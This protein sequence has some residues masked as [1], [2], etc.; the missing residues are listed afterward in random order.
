MLLDRNRSLT[1]LIDFQIRLMPAIDNRIG[2]LNRGIQL[3]KLA[4][5]MDV[6]VLATEHCPDKIGG[7]E[8]DIQAVS[9]YS[10][11]KTTFDACRTQSLFAAWQQG[12]EQVVVAGVE[13][14][15]CVFQ[16]AISLAD[17]GYKVTVA[18]D[19]IGS[20]KPLDR[21][22]AIAAMARHGIRIATVEQIGFEWLQDAEHPKFR[23]ALA[24]IKPAI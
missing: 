19:A 7:L 8:P 10:V 12:H 11:E 20:R 5:L 3:A 6:S 14:H 22:I 21:D 4:K 23:D 17:R 15:V 13:A 1:L 2:V 16:T 24:L 18:V 9:D